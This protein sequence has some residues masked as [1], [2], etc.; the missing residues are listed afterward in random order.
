MATLI[1][2]VYENKTVFVLRKQNVLQVTRLL[3]RPELL[4]A[5][6]RAIVR[7]QLRQ[8]LRDAFHPRLAAPPHHSAVLLFLLDLCHT[9]GGARFMLRFSS[10]IR[11]HV[12]GVGTG[13]EEAVKASVCLQRV[14]RPKLRYSARQV[15]N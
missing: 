13:G 3:Q 10:G 6:T 1:I 8:L 7:V 9:A 12:D 11:L 2:F 15:C 14:R 5:H 4:A